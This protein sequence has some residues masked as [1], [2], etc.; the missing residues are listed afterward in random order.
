MRSPRVR[1][2]LLHK[3]GLFVVS[4]PGIGNDV[5]GAGVGGAL[6]SQPYGLIGQLARIFGTFKRAG[7][8]GKRRELIWG[9]QAPTKSRQM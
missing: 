1:R 8:V 5:G 3:S 9:P 4:V 6:Q 7:I 2:L